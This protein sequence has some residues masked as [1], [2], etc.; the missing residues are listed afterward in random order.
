MSRGWLCL[1]AGTRGAGVIAGTYAWTVA[2]GVD[3][4]FYHVRWMP[5][6]G[7]YELLVARRGSKEQT[8]VGVQW[9]RATRPAVFWY[10]LEDFE[11]I[12]EQ[13]TGRV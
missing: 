3:M 7:M 6:A 8:W 12:W 13:G 11:T 4:N 5:A 1:C 2:R 10:V 9:I